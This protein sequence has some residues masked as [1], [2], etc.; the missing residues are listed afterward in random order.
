MRYNLNIID[1][2]IILDN[3]SSDN[4]LKILDL[5]KKEGLNVHILKNRNGEFN[6]AI[7]TNQLLSYVIINL[8]QIF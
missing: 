4:T 2:M 1:G 3:Q 5:L 7:K 6:Q 8:K